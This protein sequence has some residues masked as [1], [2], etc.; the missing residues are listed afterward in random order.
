[1]SDT[2]K[3]EDLTLEWLKLKVDKG[4]TPDYII[5]A[6]VENVGNKFF[7]KFKENPLVPIGKFFLLINNASLLFVGYAY[8]FLL[9]VFLKLKL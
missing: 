1:M 8:I 7:R 6:Q 4:K 2:S 3:N 5:K 9:L